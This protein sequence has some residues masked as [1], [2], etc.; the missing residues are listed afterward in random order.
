M[1]AKARELV[2]MV[3]TPFTR[4]S[5]TSFRRPAAHADDRSVVVRPCV[6]DDIDAL[7]DLTEQLGHSTGREE[8]SGRLAVLLA[9]PSYGT[10][11]ALDADGTPLGLLTG[12]LIHHLEQPTTAT[13]MALVIDAEAR[14]R[15][16]SQRL[17]RVFDE[18]ARANGAQRAMVASGDHSRGSHRGYEEY[19]FA[20]DGY[21]YTKPY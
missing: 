19:D 17:V 10:W 16:A 21:R 9:D 13:L 2:F 7:V 3:S 14:G 6:P 20:R 8:L 4:R 11:L 1:R 18:W 5:R 15:G 12:H